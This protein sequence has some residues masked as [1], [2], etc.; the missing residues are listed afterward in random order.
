MLFDKCK[1]HMRMRYAELLPCY[2]TVPPCGANFCTGTPDDAARLLDGRT[3]LFLGLSFD[4]LH[5]FQY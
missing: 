3:M 1:I 5:P 2:F 4:S